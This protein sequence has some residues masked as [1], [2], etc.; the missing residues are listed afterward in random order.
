VAAT[1]APDRVL[2]RRHQ[3]AGQAA[4]ARIDADHDPVQVPRRRR[5][6]RAAVAQVPEHGGVVAVGRGHQQ[7]VVGAAGQGGVDQLERDRDLVRLEGL[8]RADDRGQPLAVTGAAGPDHRRPR[9][10]RHALSAM[11]RMKRG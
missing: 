8:V 3:R 10:R 9:P 6:R 11:A 1:R 7:Q 5:H 4:T 2:H